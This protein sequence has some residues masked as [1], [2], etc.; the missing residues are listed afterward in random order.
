MRDEPYI[1]D[2]AL[3]ALGFARADDGTFVAPHDV[4]VRLVPIGKFFEF[5]ISIDGNAV[6]VVVPRVAIK[7]TCEEPRLRGRSA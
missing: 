7:I 3:V 4:I 2:D 5:R 6:C 1:T